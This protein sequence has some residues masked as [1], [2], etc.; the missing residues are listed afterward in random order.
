[1]W[2]GWC[3]C[4]GARGRRREGTVLIDSEESHPLGDARPVDSTPGPE[5]PSFSFLPTPSFA[6]FTPSLAPSS[7]LLF[8]PEHLRRAQT[9]PNRFSPRE[10]AREGQ[11]ERA[12]ER[13]GDLPKNI[14]HHPGRFLCQAR[15]YY[16]NEVLEKGDD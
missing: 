12:R 4:E 14:P 5:P 10:R 11:G 16:A 7:P 13:Q 15:G 2:V 9:L 6:L 3:R 8:V 1:M